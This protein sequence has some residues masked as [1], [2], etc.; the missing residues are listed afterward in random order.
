MN[1]V[2][3]LVV[4]IDSRSDTA[5]VSSPDVVLSHVNNR[6]AQLFSSFNTVKSL[7]LQLSR[8]STSPLRCLASPLANM[9]LSGSNLSQVKTSTLQCNTVASHFRL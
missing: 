4:Q 6:P 7:V 9:D 5:Y 2:F 8:Y 1:G 3:C